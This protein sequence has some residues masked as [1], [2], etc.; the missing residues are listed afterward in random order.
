MLDSSL[1][2]KAEFTIWA[3]HKIVPKMMF[4]KRL[5]GENK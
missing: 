1:I 4:H 3:Y 5:I 2:P